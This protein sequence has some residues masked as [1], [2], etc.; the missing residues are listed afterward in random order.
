MGLG[1]EV[2]L[3][4]VAG[5]L[6]QGWRGPAPWR[7]FEDEEADGDGDFEAGGAPSPRAVVVVNAVGSNAAAVGSIPYR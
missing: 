7:L 4:S 3:A 6:T 2:L 5:G 1:R